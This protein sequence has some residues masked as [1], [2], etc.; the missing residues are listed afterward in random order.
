M[1]RK[2]VLVW[3]PAEADFA[4]RICVQTVYI[5]GDPRKHWQRNGEVIQKKEDS[6]QRG[7]H[8]SRLPLRA[9]GADPTR[10][11]DGQCEHASVIPTNTW[12]VGVSMHQLSICPCWGQLLGSCRR[13]QWASLQSQG[14]CKEDSQKQLCLGRFPNRWPLNWTWSVSRRYI[15]MRRRG[16]RWCQR[17]N[18]NYHSPEVC[19]AQSIHWC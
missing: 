2:A 11:S 4:T 17:R 19:G 3:I 14:E 6:Q 9:T 12:R 5:G 1:F 16:R 7:Y 15:A 8:A 10:E 13:S 18:R